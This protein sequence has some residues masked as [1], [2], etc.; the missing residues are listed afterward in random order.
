MERN[1][2]HVSQP[3]SSPSS[4]FPSLRSVAPP[5]MRNVSSRTRNKNRSIA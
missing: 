5:E 2:R 4:E 1:L 3:S